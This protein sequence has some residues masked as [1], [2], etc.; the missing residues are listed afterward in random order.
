MR[1]EASLQKQTHAIEIDDGV[2]DIEHVHAENPGESAAA[3]LQGEI[4]QRSDTE[5]LRRHFERADVEVVDFC[6]ADPLRCSAAELRGNPRRFGHE[7]KRFNERFVQRSN[8]C[9]GIDQQ[10]RRLSTD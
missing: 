9:T 5:F 10:T 6:R 3:L 2:V 4:R 7:S 1:G 8:K